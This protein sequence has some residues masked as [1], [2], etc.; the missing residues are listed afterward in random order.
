MT[1]N[2]IM[3]ISLFFC[4]SALSLILI[5]FLYELQNGGT[6]NGDFLISVNYK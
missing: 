1:I 2:I 4:P 3:F 5:F 6:K